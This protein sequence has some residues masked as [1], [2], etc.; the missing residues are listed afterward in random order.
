MAI[1]KP[2]HANIKKKSDVWNKESQAQLANEMNYD[3]TLY[4]KAVRFIRVYDFEFVY[5]SPFITTCQTK[6]GVPFAPHVLVLH[7]RRW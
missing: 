7:I 5:R 3:R 6:E 2:N 4:V 1:G